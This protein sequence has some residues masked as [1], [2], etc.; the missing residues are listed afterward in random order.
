MPYTGR[1]RPA[2]F[3]ASRSR[4]LANRLSA[5]DSRS[6]SRPSSPF[7]ATNTPLSQQRSQQSRLSGELDTSGSIAN[8]SNAGSSMD[9]PESVSLGKVF[10]ECRAV[11]V[12]VER[13][14]GRLHSV[15]EK[16]SKILAAIKELNEL[17][18][19]YCKSSFVIKGS[20]YEV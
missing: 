15:E 9:N 19:K 20:Q 18:K 17:T 8:N 14:S 11:S 5:N 2:R 12:R 10:D 16:T 4:G 13:I 3:S 7:T 6:S 1:Q